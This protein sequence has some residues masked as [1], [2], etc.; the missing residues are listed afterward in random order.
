MGLGKTI[1]VLAVLSLLRRK[2]ESGTDLLVVPASLIDNWHTE[3]QRFA[4]QLEPLIAHPSHIP[5]RDLKAL[6]TSEV[7]DKDVVITTYG[8]V[9]RTE[10]MRDHRWRC[11][12]LDEA[13]AIKNPGTKQTRAIKA[14]KAKWRLALTGTPVENKLGDLWSIF[15][16]LNP[17]LLGSAKAFNAFC[18]SLA[19]RK[20]NAYAPLRKL[21]QPYILRRLKTDKNVIVDLPDKTE[22][23]AHCLL[24]KQQAAL[25]QKSVQEMRHTIEE[26]EGIKRRG[27]VLAFLM[28]FKQLCNHPSQWLGDNAYDPQHSGKFARLRELCEPMAARQ[29]KVLIF[30]QFREMTGPLAVFLAE[31]FGRP[32][33]VLHGGTAV[34]K[35]QSL[36]KQF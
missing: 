30:T 19:S 16:F 17:G 20:H 34:K 5:T 31:V 11:V 1:Q 4:P 25:Y 22:V 8:T 35:R 26:V 24:S 36:V 12:I 28:R 29:D 3:M 32:G 14:L 7:D 23:T 21:V 9:M 15:D 18:K 33:L 13:Q 2:K 10:W 6:P 27:V